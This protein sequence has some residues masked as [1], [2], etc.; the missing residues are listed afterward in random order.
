[1]N[2]AVIYIVIEYFGLE[3]SLFKD[4]LVPTL[5]TMAAHMSGNSGELE[6]CW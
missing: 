1:M 3:E 4:H 2:P 6:L 5:S